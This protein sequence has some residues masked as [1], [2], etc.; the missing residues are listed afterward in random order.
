MLYTTSAAALAL[1]EVM[2]HAP[3]I[4]FE[5]LLNTGFSKSKFLM[6]FVF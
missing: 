1:V 3:N 5:D 6:T 2:A 4:R